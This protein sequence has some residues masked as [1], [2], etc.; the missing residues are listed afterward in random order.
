M[1]ST[2][3][4]IK[5]SCVSRRTLKGTVFAPIGG[6][7]G[8]SLHDEAQKKGRTVSYNAPERLARVQSPA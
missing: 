3:S 7:G 5:R 2:V 8:Q 4:P 6:E 1:T